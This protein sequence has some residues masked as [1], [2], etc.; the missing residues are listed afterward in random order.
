MLAENIGRIKNNFKILRNMIEQH[1][2]MDKYEEDIN[3]IVENIGQT[4]AKS[5]ERR[6][7]A[8]SSEILTPV[9]G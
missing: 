4:I 8:S 9:S 2:N 3:F 7:R 5:E 1:H 6:A